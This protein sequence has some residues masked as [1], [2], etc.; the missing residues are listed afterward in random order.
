MVAFRRHYQR[1]LLMLVWLCATTQEVLANAPMP[2]KPVLERLDPARRAKVLAAV[3]ALI[4]LGIG[5]MFLAWLGAK[6]TRRYMNRE[7]I[8]R[9]KP[10]TGTP[11][12][13]K[14]WA[15]KPL[16]SPLEE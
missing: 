12:R 13:E 9:E 3:A 10:P 6:A 16:S 8:L 14:D 15:E 5:L 7:P 2:A 1:Y 4:I 11:I